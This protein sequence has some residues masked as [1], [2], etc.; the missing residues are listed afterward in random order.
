[1]TR[2]G[3]PVALTTSHGATAAS[4]LGSLYHSDFWAIDSGIV[5]NAGNVSSWPN[6][7]LNGA[8][9]VQA[10][11]ANQ[12]AYSASSFNGQPGVT[13]DGV[14]DSL[15]ATMSTTSP[16]GARIVV[17][18]AVQLVAAPAAAS[19]FLEFGQVARTNVM[20]FGCPVGSGATFGGRATLSDGTDEAAGTLTSDTNRHVLT[21]ML[22]NSNTGRVQEDATLANGTFHGTLDGTKDTI[23]L[24]SSCAPGG[25]TNV[26]YHRIIIAHD[27]ANPGNLPSAGQIAAVQALLARYI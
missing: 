13:F 24:G 2:P 4:I 16:A 21:Y 18:A 20:L 19:V 14:N 25:F 12:P 27:P 7:G 9:A 5:L 17:F 22:I 15:A 8:A 3:F 23:A 11:A 10:T 1:M 26:R 6:R